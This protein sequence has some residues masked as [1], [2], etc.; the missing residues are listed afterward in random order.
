MRPSK[1]PLALFAALLV[2]SSGTTPVVISQSEA[3]YVLEVDFGIIGSE[4]DCDT[5]SDEYVISQSTT[6]P[7]WETRRTRDIG[8]AIIR[9]GSGA[10]ACNSSAK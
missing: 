8:A 9:V 1:L 3:P 4:G 10:T 5:S 2:I 7:T 6:M